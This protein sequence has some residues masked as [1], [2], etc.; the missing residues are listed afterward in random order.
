MLQKILTR[1]FPLVIQNSLSYSSVDRLDCFVYCPASADTR[2][3][4]ETWGWIRSGGYERRRSLGGE[5]EVML[6]LLAFASVPIHF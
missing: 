6:I 3:D 1:H 5:S 2:G 4:R